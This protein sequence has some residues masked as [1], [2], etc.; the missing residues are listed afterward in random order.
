MF[1]QSYTQHRVAGAD[2]QPNPLITVN[3][4]YIRM[5]D[6][7]EQGKVVYWID[8]INNCWVIKYLK[9]NTPAGPS[10]VQRDA[11]PPR[12]SK[13]SSS[14]RNEAIITIIDDRPETAHPTETFNSI[15]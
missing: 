14:E 2:I 6:A 11:P 3:G 7:E 13:R 10:K 1:G 15:I 9:E 12:E 5:D 8:A 4:E